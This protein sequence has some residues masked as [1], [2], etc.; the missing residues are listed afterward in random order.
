MEWLL[1]IELFLNE[2][3]FKSLQDAKAKI[4]NWRQDYNTKRPHQ[5][6]RQ[7][8]PL[9]YRKKLDFEITEKKKEL[10]LAMA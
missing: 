2:N 7:M 8:T 4:D 6:L 5:S 3:W 10:S 9:E 1:L